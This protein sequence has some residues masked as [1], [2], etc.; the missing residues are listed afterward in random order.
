MTRGSRGR[1]VSVFRQ[2]LL[3]LEDTRY[4]PPGLRGRSVYRR[5]YVLLTHQIETA[6]HPGASHDDRHKFQSLLE[7]RHRPRGRPG[8]I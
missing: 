5:V 7:S 6:K 3:G 1:A 4:P 8:S 2:M